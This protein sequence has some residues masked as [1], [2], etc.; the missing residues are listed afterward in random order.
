[1][2]EA[3]RRRIF[4]GWLGQHRGLIFK[5]VR[6]YAHT[7]MDRDDLFQEVAVQLWR[8]VSS[9]KGESKETTWIYRVALNTAMRWL[10]VEKRRDRIDFQ[11]AKLVLQ[12]SPS[13]ID[14]QLSWLYAEIAQLDELERSLALMLLDD[15]SYKEMATVLGITE[16]NVGVR[17]HRIKK[18][19]ISKSKTVDRYGV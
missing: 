6:A 7:E 18:Y 4:Q 12:E 16:S 8:S 9:F 19:L 3:E 11:E 5:I 10:H 13:P 17:I 15:L 2:G 14:Q 1:V